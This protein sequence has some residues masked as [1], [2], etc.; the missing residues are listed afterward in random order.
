M[1]VDNA[2]L[3]TAILQ[4][5]CGVCSRVHDPQS[6]LTKSRLRV[7]REGFYPYTIG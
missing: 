4:L 7:K 1:T 3:E 2:S 6:I 5:W